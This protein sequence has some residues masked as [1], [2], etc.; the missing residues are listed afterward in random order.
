MTIFTLPLFYKE[1]NMTAKRILAMAISLCMLLGL[2][3]CTFKKIEVPTDKEVKRAVEDE[4]DKKFKL[5]S[6]DVSKDGSEAEWVFIAKDGTLEVTVTWSAKKPDKFDM[7][8]EVLI[9]VPSQSDAKR[10]VEETYGTSFDMIYEHISDDESEAEWL[11][12]DK[13]ETFE[14]TVY[15]SSS[16]PEFHF[17]EEAYPGHTD[18]PGYNSG[19]P[20]YG[21]GDEVINLWTYSSDATEIVQKFIELHPD[22]AD[23]YTIAVTIVPNDGGAYQEA[24]DQALA[25]GEDKAPD[26]YFADVSYVTKYTQGDM[27]KFAAA[28]ED[29]GIDV[30]NKIKSAEIA[31]YTVDIGSRDGQVVALAYQATGGAMI[32]RASIAKEVF[33]TDDP[34]EIE[35]IFGAG[36]GSWDKFLDAANTLKSSGYKV[37]SGMDDLWQVCA[38]GASQ[39]WVDSN[40]NLVISPER[41]V[42]LD[43]AKKLI[44]EDLSNDY[45]AWTEGWYYDM[46]NS[47]V[48]CYFGP[49]WMINYVMTGNC[50]GDHIGEGTYGDW[51][52]CVPP[53]GYFWG[54]SWIL[55]NKNTDQKEGVAELIEWI[56]LDTSNTGLQYLWANGMM[57]Y[58]YMDTV[59]SNVVMAKSNGTCDFCGGQNVYEVYINCN[60]IAY[61]MAM[62][63]YDETINYFFADYAEQYAYGIYSRD[64]ALA[65]FKD[66]VVSGHI[67]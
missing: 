28:Y 11:F 14:V 27:S 61:G 39:P 5:D 66:D 36:S 13:D 67:Y 26:I 32:Y 10:F 33:G 54:G 41:E 53:V 6:S 55:A 51:R 49:D 19:N 31:Q 12:I 37:V 1:D 60:N 7:D 63:Q 45:M 4:Y 3:A 65:R 62:T 21:H 8:E 15:W 42:Y 56:T 22:F 16:N 58:G 52:V 9:E 43:L 35:R 48:F 24:L 34:N 57:N 29:L 46:Q 25:A 20:G 23:K 40:R 44:D 30:D 47:G 59:A 64:E 38:T 17:Y 2:A 18:D 50:G